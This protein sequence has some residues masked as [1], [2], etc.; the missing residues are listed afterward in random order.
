MGRTTRG[1][2][3]E[4]GVTEAFLSG[5]TGPEAVVHVRD[6]AD[7]VLDVRPVED[8]RA[9]LVRLR[10]GPHTLTFLVH[11]TG[12]DRDAVSL[13]LAGG[14][15]A[16]VAGAAGFLERLCA[17][18]GGGVRAGPHDEWR[19]VHRDPAASDGVAW[20]TEARIA[21]AGMLEF[22]HGPE[23][24]VDATDTAWLQDVADRMTSL[25]EVAC[26]AD[27]SPTSGVGR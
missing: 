20:T 13:E 15:D 5:V 16:G 3:V 8:G 23:D 26:D 6:L 18:T 27:P 22:D 17:R 4:I 1:A 11:G 7:E 21:L 10:T 12:P 25:V 14:M 24:L 9:R 2:T 19:T